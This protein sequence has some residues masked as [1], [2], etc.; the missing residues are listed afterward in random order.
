MLR[1]KTLRFLAAI[2][3]GLLLFFLATL[4]WPVHLDT[5]K[6]V[7]LVALYFSILIFHKLGIPGLLEHN[8]LCG[9]GWCEPTWLGWAFASVI[10][11]I[12]LWLAAWVLAGLASRSSIN[13][14]GK[15]PRRG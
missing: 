7:L 10:W 8:G 2:L 5:P 15:P 3:A 4:F 13:L 14:A 6:A 9:W 1:P 11:L 12:I